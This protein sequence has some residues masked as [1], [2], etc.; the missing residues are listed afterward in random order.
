MRPS[1]AAYPSPVSVRLEPVEGRGPRRSRPLDKRRG[2]GIAKRLRRHL[3]S[4]IRLAVL[5]LAMTGGA[6]A[7]RPDRVDAM[8]YAG[9]VDYRRSP[10]KEDAVFGGLYTYLGFGMEHLVEAAFDRV[11]LD[12]DVGGTLRQ[13][14]VTIAYSNFSRP[15]WK[16][17]AGG[18]FVSGDERFGGDGWVGF[19]GAHHFEGQAWETGV[20][21]YRSNFDNPGSSDGI[22]QVSP[23]VGFTARSSPAHGFRNDLTAHLIYLDRNPGLNRQDFASVEEKLTY[24]WNRWS[25]SAYGWAGE[26]V[27]AVRDSGFLVYNLAEKHKGGRGLSAR[28]AFGATTAV[29]LK[30]ARELFNDIGTTATAEANTVSFAIAHTF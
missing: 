22:W 7:A 17:R 15:G 5:A 14:D 19:L 3:G 8:L 25:L 16:L 13:N 10:V 1:S 29:T 20:D 11:A 23:H 12:F 4:A 6:F 26:Q 18:H 24:F 27:F 9:S 30:T 2:N 28:Y 21:L